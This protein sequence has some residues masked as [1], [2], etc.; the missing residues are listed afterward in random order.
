MDPT[1]SDDNATPPPPP[2]PGPGARLADVLANVAGLVK[3]VTANVGRIAEDVARDAGEV[4]RDAEALGR[5]A[6]AQWF[7]LVDGARATPRLTRVV[8]AGAKLL[9]LWRWHRLRALA[10]GEDPVDNP[11][12]H[13]A[14]A[15]AAYDACVEL[16]GGILKLGQIASARPDLLPA[17]WIEELSNLQDRVPPVSTESIV[18]Q[19]E[20]EWGAS[21]LDKLATFEAEAL[22]AASL[23]QVHAATLPGATGPDAAP[24]VEVV[25]KVQVP[26]IADVVEADIGALRVLARLAKDIVPGVELAP[27]A[28]E[29]GRALAEELDYRREADNLADFAAAARA[30]GDPVVVPPVVAYLSTERVMVMERVPGERL[31][32][33]LDRLT[34]AGDLATR[35]RILATIVE[36]VARQVLVHGVVH[37]DPHPGNFLVTPDGQLAVLDFGCVL[38]QTPAQRLAWARLF[39]ALIARDEAR[40]AHE[41]AALG[42]VADDEAALLGLAAT[43]VDAMRP[44]A[45]LATIDFNAQLQQLTERL[46]AAG[47]AG[48]SIHAP[49]SFVLLA[50]VLGTIAGM[51]VRYR[52]SLQ[53]FALIAPMLAQA[54]RAA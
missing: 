31:N 35:D 23:A 38:R 7:G 4:A 39:M 11:V 13:R 22:A 34:A 20:A 28:A 30:S 51:L 6:Q 42:F 14:L 27:I 15:R 1:M 10:R 45:D 53:P 24:H 52:P 2:G 25:V 43:I 44:G 36:S 32:D 49:P 48:G 21:V 12:I 46:A 47:R 54:A 41:L 50:R 3:N 9:A 19:I 29:L 26:G 16:R 8:A 18:A 40:A 5:A 33:A 37:A 17:P